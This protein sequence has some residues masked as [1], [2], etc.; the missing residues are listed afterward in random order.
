[1]IRNDAQLAQ[2]REALGPLERSLALL[3]RDRAQLHPDR[4]ALMAAPVLD[5]LLKLRQDIDDYL[6]VTAA[7]HASVPLW[8]KLEGPDL[9]LDDAPSSVVT[10][11]IDILRIGVQTVAE[12]L[13]KGAVGARPT[14]K[15]KEACEL[16]LA[17]W[18]PGS[19]QVGLQLPVL[20]PDLFEEME[21]SKMARDALRIYLI[22]AAWV[23]S[24]EEVHQLA[25]VLPE[26][27]QRRVVLNQI[28]RLIPRP[29]GRLETVELSGRLVSGS[30]RLCRKS[31]QRVR[32]A[33]KETVHEEIVR[34]EGILREIDLDERSFVLRDPD[35][36]QETRCSVRPEATDLIEIA[37]SGLDH[38][39]AVAGTRRRD[40]TRRQVFPLLVQEI[41]VLDA[42]EDSSG[43]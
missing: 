33:I 5:D 19:I 15:L 20:D 14:A 3:Q 21:L 39:V 7:I 27:E 36:D 6:G 38:R 22:G 16:R 32:E 24:E 40:P 8:L 12:Y 11:L 26:A 9:S 25:S 30:V 18:Q 35:T 37:K 1:M 17:A 13:V 41:D 31:R 4:Y 43:E 2:Y 28:A 23:G 34:A 42:A 29:R 10:S